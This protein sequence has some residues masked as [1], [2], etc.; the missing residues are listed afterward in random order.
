MDV[1][2]EGKRARLD[3]RDSVSGGE[4]KVFFLKDSAVKIYH[5]ENLNAMRIEKLRH[6][7]SDLPDKV[8]SP[9]SLV[10]D[11]RGNVIGFAMR[12][13]SGAEPFLMLANL[14][15]RANFPDAEVKELFLDARETLA[16]THAKRAVI[17]DLNSLN[18]MFAGKEALFIDADSIQFGRFPCEVA[19]ERFLDP[20]LYGADY[21][22]LVFTPGSDWYSFAVMLFESLLFVHPF[23]GVHPKYPTLER[24]AQSGL[25]VMDAGVKYPKAARRFDILPDGLLDYFQQTFEKGDRRIIPKELIS[26]LEW[27]TCPG[28]GRIHARS[29]CPFCVGKGPERQTLMAVNRQC[30]ATSVIRTRGRIILAVVQGGSL[31]AIVEEKGKVKRENGEIILDVNPDNFTRFAIMG[32]RTLIGRGEK[33]VV[34]ENGK[35]LQVEMTG[36]L[37]NLP[38]FETDGTDYF[39]ICGDHLVKGKDEIVGQVLAG[40]TWIRS[41]PDRGFGFYRIGRK[42]VYFIFD[43]RKPGINDGIR[44]PAISGKLIDAEALFSKDRILFMHSAEE[45]GRIMN[46]MHLLDWQGEVIA[47]LKEEAARSRIVSGI[48]NKALSG[49]RILIATDAGLV[50]VEAR[51]GTFQEIRTFPETEPFVSEG[52]QILPAPDGTYVVTAKEASL[53]RLL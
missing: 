47:S 31:K 39:R 38:V 24:R 32:R 50:L 44:L 14:K 41:G 22:R 36:M 51:G 52:A 9:R 11:L 16:A 37:G 26:D 53:L 19:M 6:F 7:P 29:A 40:Q 23:G 42:T 18:V 48:H 30:S 17:G 13:I 2:M 49:S 1:I 10:E 25:T 33:L 4:A 28:C 5:P 35:A 34:A 27:K 43:T 12:R 15:F 3:D 21:S 45:K 8:I 20:R 46:S